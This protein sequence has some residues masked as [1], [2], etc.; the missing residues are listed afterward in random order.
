MPSAHLVFSLIRHSDFVI[1]S[2][3]RMPYPSF[4]RARRF[5][6]KSVGAAVAV[7]VAGI[8]AAVVL[9]LLV[10]VVPLVVELLASGGGLTVSAPDHFVLDQWHV[11]PIA[12]D[13]NTARY[14]RCGLLPLVWRLR[15]TALGPASRWI[16]TS[17]AALRGNQSCLAAL[18]ICVWVLALFAATTLYWLDIAIQRA[19][20]AVTGEL[21]EQIHRQAHRLGAGDL[22]VG[23][24]VTAAELFTDK[25]E[26]LRVAFLAWWKVVPHAAVFEILMLA[27]A[28]AVDFWL[29]LVTI[30]LTGISWWLISALRSR[31]R[32]R[33]AAL[34]DNARVTASLLVEQLRQN[35]LLGN[36]TIENRAET[37][38][39]H[40]D[41]QRYN[42]TVAAQESAAAPWCRWS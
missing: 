3:V 39:F 5:G 35:R 30:L 27:L 31:S 24:R 12:I 21:R 22:F 17:T 33:Q 26:A 28:L 18:I 9:A 36:L 1:S 13:A 19:A 7:S 16:F 38:T 11:T 42:E 34:A 4:A 6:R 40:D 20:L 10:M 15:E 8:A 32:R 41:L 2:E 29:S 37:G 23:Q 14:E 25:T